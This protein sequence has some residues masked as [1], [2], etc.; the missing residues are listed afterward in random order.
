MGDL[1]MLTSKDGLRVKKLLGISDELFEEFKETARENDAK[2][3]HKHETRLVIDNSIPKI[4]IKKG[5][6]KEFAE[7]YNENIEGNPVINYILEDVFIKEGYITLS[8]LDFLDIVY[9]DEEEVMFMIQQ[10]QK[11]EL[12]EQALEFRERIENFYNKIVSKFEIT[13]GLV[14]HQ[15]MWSAAKSVKVT[16]A[17]VDEELFED[18][19]GIDMSAVNTKFTFHIET[20]EDED[21]FGYR[22]VEPIAND[23]TVP[24]ITLMVQA[25]MYMLNKHKDEFLI[26]KENLNQ[27]IGKSNN[28]EI[29]LHRELKQHLKK[30]N[31]P[32][33]Y[34]DKIVW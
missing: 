23:D 12:I 7:F 13:N 27:R 28:E 6:E 3:K 4:Y 31:V 16:E 21:T 20:H 26:T 14:S 22:L 32:V 24:T 1:K 18:L 8:F 33:Y 29:D 5:M 10:Y 2:R 11:P 34:I 15:I 25:M 17:T 30:S 9:P 19:D